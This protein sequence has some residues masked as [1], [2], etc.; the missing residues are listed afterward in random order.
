MRIAHVAAPAAFGGLE[1]VVAALAA[2]TASA[3]HEVTVVLVLEPGV[4]VPL[5]AEAL[6]DRS[7]RVRP[8]HL[9]ARAYVR[10][11]REVRALLGSERVQVVHTHGFRPDV[12]HGGVARSLRIPV[13]STA[14]GFAST[15]GIGRIYEW[16]QVGAWR[17][18]DAV[19]AV[20]RPLQ[21]DLAKA[22]VPARSLEFIPNGLGD[23]AAPRAT[24]QEARQL[25]GLPEDAAVIGWVGRLSPEKD[26]LAML[27]AFASVKNERAWLC[28]IGDGPLLEACR[29]ASATPR[30][31]DRV[32]LAGGRPSAS[33]LFAAFD[34]LALSSRTEGTPMV[35]LEAAT[36]RLPVISTAVGGVP[37]L[38]GD[39]AGWLVPAGAPAALAE[40]IDDAL[41]QRPEAKSRAEA[42]SARLVA[43]SSS[44]VAQYIALYERL[45]ANR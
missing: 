9:P 45:L 24:R 36:A 38:L 21:G 16:L 19:V 42:L 31:R 15:D 1:S 8:L 25:L 10:E 3:G 14:H 12:L 18:F 29:E 33:R 40:A 7:V 20:S 4:A 5:W 43:S 39:G 2:G 28:M 30:L 41:R 26:P 32:L 35:I 13:V 34:V 6:E 22:G 17:R 23:D 37:D 11:R 44:W 27:E